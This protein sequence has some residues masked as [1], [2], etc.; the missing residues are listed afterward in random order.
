[1][2]A[3]SGRLLIFRFP[4]WPPFHDCLSGRVGTACKPSCLCFAQPP[5]SIR[6]QQTQAGRD[7]VASVCWQ[8]V[9]STQFTEL[10]PE[11]LGPPRGQK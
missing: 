2:A 4:V 3:A 1:M 9:K 10:M 6:H 8:E 5:A 11:T 7:C